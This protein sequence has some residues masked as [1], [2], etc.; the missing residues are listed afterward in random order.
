MTIPPP[1]QLV[2]VGNESVA[3]PAG[4]ETAVRLQVAAPLV[5]RVTAT[6]PPLLVDSVVDCGVNVPIVALGPAYA[7]SEASRSP[8]DKP[9]DAPTIECPEPNPVYLKRTPELTGI[10]AD[11]VT[12]IE[13]L[14][15]AG[16][17]AGDGARID[18]VA[19]V[20]GAVFV[21]GVT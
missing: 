1:A 19:G 15:T 18:E 10:V 17:R 20:E 13:F 21:Y 2:T 12:V 16:R 6:F 4:I 3:A 11:Q 5:P 7:L 8:A 14:A 9:P